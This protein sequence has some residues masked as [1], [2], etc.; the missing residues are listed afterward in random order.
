M[1]RS[2]GARDGSPPLV[3]RE[4]QLDLLG[5]WATEAA[6]GQG[7]I[8]VIIAEAG[9]GKTALLEAFR[10]S[11][12]S[13][14]HQG[15]CDSLFA[16]SVM[17]PFADIAGDLGIVTADAPGLDGSREQLLRA[18]L[19]R[20]GASS[21]LQ[22]LAIED[23]HWADEATLDLLRL[24]ARRIGS[25]PVLLLVTCRDE[26]ADVPEPVDRIV[27][28]LARLPGGRR[29]ELPPL[30]PAGCAELCAGTDWEPG[31]L[32]ELTGGNPFF[33]TERLAA[34]GAETPQSIRDLV[35]AR[36]AGAPDD[37]WGAAELAALLGPRVD[38]PGNV[39]LQLLDEAAERE[40]LARGI[41]V[42]DADGLRFRHEITRRVVL[43]AMSS[44]RRLALH[45]RILEVLSRTDPSDH[46][47][48]AFHAAGADD[49]AACLEHSRRAAATAAR[50]GSMHDAVAHLER[51]IVA[52]DDDADVRTRASLHDELADALGLLD[53]FDE[54]IAARQRARAMWTEL[55]DRVLLADSLRRGAWVCSSA[56]QSEQAFADVRRGLELLEPGG[57]S[58]ELAAAHGAMAR[59][60]GFADDSAAALPHLRA[61]LEIALELDLRSM[62]A[63]LLNVEACCLAMLGR[64][65]EPVMQ[66]S[67]DVASAIPDDPLVARANYNT[68]NL[69]IL[70]SRLADAEGGYASALRH[71]EEHCLD[72]YAQGL[73]RLRASSLVQRGRWD[74]AVELAR[75]D[76]EIDRSSS[77][78]AHLAESGVVLATVAARRG[79]PIDGDLLDDILRAAEQT[80][81]TQFIVPARLARAE[82]AWLRNDIDTAWKEL[83]FARDLGPTQVHQI[84]DIELWAHRTGLGALGTVVDGP[85][86][87]EIAGRYEDA[88]Q[89]WDRHGCPFDAAVALL[90]SEDEASL[91]S[92]IRKLEQLGA[93]AT[94]QV[95]RAR[96]RS[97]GHASIPSRPNRATREHPMGLTSRECDV[98]ELLAQ[99]MRNRDIADRLYVSPKTVAVHVGNILRK[100]G[101]INRGEAAAWARANPDS[102]RHP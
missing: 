22:L 7:R 56:G 94:A 38:R 96:M 28:D 67:L 88:S 10:S 17:A 65:W 81:Q 30:T 19:H 58:P 41:L 44:R 90:G 1:E 23:V 78:P 86:A 25:M 82:V 2:A 69:R 29:M 31:R 14:W 34:P 43:D 5:R 18:L 57:P 20:L 72:T 76:V 102:L 79:E 47:L 101:V 92:A 16:A 6:A 42:D 64:P 83:R 66:R 100:L 26:G 48:L 40:L 9:G 54:S 46:A 99:G 80:A 51:A 91:Q 62:Q 77:T 32:H 74:E 36:F 97:L 11:I 21:S 59:L 71:A 95:A 60:L 45:G 85:A 24:L 61:G 89:Q 87:L 15:Y 50:A 98:L 93:S 84:R 35:R 49:R 4:H 68:F 27:A 13:P 73:R 37:V 39:R 53:R 33:V 52:A 70:E 8:A 55:G 12:S 63:E 3:E 75:R